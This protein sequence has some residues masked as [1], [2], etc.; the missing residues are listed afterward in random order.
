ML[1]SLAES[2][3]NPSNREPATA[4][5]VGQL[6]SLLSDIKESLHDEVGKMRPLHNHR[7]HRAMHQFIQSRK[8]LAQKIPEFLQAA[9]NASIQAVSTQAPLATGDATMSLHRVDPAVQRYVWGMEPP[10]LVHAMSGAA[11]GTPEPWAE[12]WFGVHPRAPSTL[13]NGMPLTEFIASNPALGF[14]PFLLKA[15]SIAKPLSIQAHPDQELAA[16][17]HARRPDIYPDASHK[18]ELMIAVKPTRVLC[19]FKTSAELL[20]LVGKLPALAAA[21]GAAAF[22][23]FNSEPWSGV[24]GCLTHLFDHP[25]T[26]EAAIAEL[27]AVDGVAAFVHGFFGTDVGVIVAALLQH[28]TLQPG[29]AVFIPANELHC[30]LS[31]EGIEVMV[32]SDNVVRCGLTGKLIDTPTLLGMVSGMHAEMAQVTPTVSGPFRSF[33]CPAEFRV[34]GVTLDGGNTEAD[35]EPMPGPLFVLCMTGE[36]EV[37][38]PMG[39]SAV[40]C[41]HQCLFAGIDL[42]LA[43]LRMRGRGEAIIVAPRV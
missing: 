33:D 39:S 7:S 3:A 17:L 1:S 4:E 43:G 21:F 18:P 35:V 34:V 31:G 40:I 36:V 12:A 37:S 6:Y 14:P 32:S 16:T 24:K 30:Y 22:D 11:D 28:R 29:E 13:P 9:A 27:V 20:E 23:A 2:A 26:H 10:C 25:E 15:L 42:G 8:D 5:S 41:A 19:G 38:T